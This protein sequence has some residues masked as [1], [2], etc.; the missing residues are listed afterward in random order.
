[1]VEEKIFYIDVSDFSIYSILL[2][3]KYG[4]SIYLRIFML[5]WTF[6]LNSLRIK[7]SLLKTDFKH[8]FYW[9]Y[10]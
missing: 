7:I 4:F 10:F 5:I 6:N 9:S 2:V 8:N 1:M 3:Q